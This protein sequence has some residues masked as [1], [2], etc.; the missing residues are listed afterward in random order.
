MLSSTC[1]MQTETLLREENP[2]AGQLPQSP[3]SPQPEVTLGECFP[4]LP[5]SVG[6]DLSEIPD[7]YN[8]TW[9]RTNDM[10]TLDALVSNDNVGYAE[11]D[12]CRDIEN[13]C[14]PAPSTNSLW[15]QSPYSQLDSCDYP[16]TSPNPSTPKHSMQEFPELLKQKSAY[17][18]IPEMERQS[19][20]SMV[21]E[22]LGPIPNDNEEEYHEESPIPTPFLDDDA[23]IAHP[24]PSFTHAELPS[25]SLARH[26]NVSW[27]GEFVP[28]PPLNNRLRAASEDATLYSSYPVNL[29]PYFTDAPVITHCSD[30]AETNDN[31][32]NNQ[33]NTTSDESVCTQT[34]VSDVECQMN[35][36]VTDVYTTS[37]VQQEM[38][39]EDSLTL[40]SV[41]QQIPVLPHAV[42]IVVDQ[43]DLS[44]IEIGD[45]QPEVPQNVVVDLTK[46]EPATSASIETPKM[47]RTSSYIRK[48]SKNNEACRESRKKRKVQ[49][50]EAAE[51]MQELTDDNELL[52]K[53]I[54]ELEQEVKETRAT[55]LTEMT[56]KSKK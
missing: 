3:G 43:S 33:V 22:V 18:S 24:S 31:N 16:L 30:T 51:K 10:E 32:N 21:L 27:G 12:Y 29:E 11:T 53:K 19:S 7:A 52:R 14:S 54:V 37:V 55:L 15:A 6:S 35:M 8:M 23:H 45:M 28:S 48:R 38:V 5:I 41:L 50:D 20:L 1:I 44:T 34:T 4:D 9:N 56:G 25:S 49:R 46:E 2:G 26:R 39:R 17:H 36:V 13:K 47:K 40:E 42:E